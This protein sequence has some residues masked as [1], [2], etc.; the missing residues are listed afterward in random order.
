M[1]TANIYSNRRKLR[2]SFNI[3]HRNSR[4]Q[5]T[6]QKLKEIP[7]EMK[8]TN[9]NRRPIVFLFIQNASGLGRVSSIFFRVNPTIP[10]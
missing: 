1:D 7:T 6:W 8:N 10:R 2:I 9:R 5:R 4:R 3:A